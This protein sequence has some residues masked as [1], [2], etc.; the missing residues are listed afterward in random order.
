MKDALEKGVHVVLSTGRWLGNSYPY[1]E[2]LGL[3]SY[4]I[5]VNGGQIWTMDKELV[6]EH[7]LETKK[8]EQMHYLAREMGVDSWM[9]ATDGVFRNILPNDYL[10]RKWLKFG[11]HT[12]DADKLEKIIQ[13][14]SH[15]DTLE[16]TNSMP[17]NIEVNPI[18]VHKASALRKVCAKLG[19][20]ME[21]VLAC[22]DSLN[23]MKMIQEA[24]I[25][26]AMGNAQEAIKNA[27][28][29]VTDHHNHDGV[30]K[31]IAKFVL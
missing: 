20:S 1:A 23:D 16:L 8:L 14:L 15:D 30:G 9:V 2:E 4:L 6:E 11:C 24:G 7:L 13:E 18:G 26:V 10:E 28:D 22:G 17:N 29:Y 3:T 31:A 27:A 19:F 5:T 12:D 25:G 21:N